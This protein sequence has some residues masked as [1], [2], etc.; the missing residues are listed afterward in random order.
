M[1]AAF[2]TG[3]TMMADRGL[4]YVVAALGLSVLWSGG[5]LAE[6]SWQGYAPRCQTS[7]LAPQPAAGDP[8]TG[9]MATFGIAGP[10]V[11]S[12]SQGFDVEATGSIKSDRRETAGESARA[13]M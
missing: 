2:F 5:A 9:Q 10:T 1:E 12:R 4:K 8:C 3:G 11:L 7:E 6:Q 13:P